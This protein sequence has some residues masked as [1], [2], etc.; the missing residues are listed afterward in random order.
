MLDPLNLDLHIHLTVHLNVTSNRASLICTHTLVYNPENPII[1]EFSVTS[2]ISTYIKLLYCHN[3]ITVL[4]KLDISDIYTLPSKVA[5]VTI[6]VAI[7]TTQ[8]KPDGDILLLTIY[9]NPGS[10]L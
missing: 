8:K 7:V 9:Q 5:I 3:E 4:M 2:I 1:S 6:Q 10:V